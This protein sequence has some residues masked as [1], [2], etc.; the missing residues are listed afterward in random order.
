MAASGAGRHLAPA[1]QHQRLPSCWLRKKQLCWRTR[2]GGKDG[3]G[4]SY[5]SISV[6]QAVR[7][8]NACMSSCFLSAP[9]LLH[10]ISISSIAWRR[11]ARRSR[12]SAS[13][14]DNEMV[15]SPEVASAFQ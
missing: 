9:L 10:R 6:S 3:S 2:L 8:S 15:V 7:I 11:L 12:K 5:G 1:A 14:T 4:G 13:R